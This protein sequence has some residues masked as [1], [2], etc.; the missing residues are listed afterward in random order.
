[1]NVQL[2]ETLIMQ[3]VLGHNLT[4][5]DVAE[6]QDLAASNVSDSVRKVLL[7]LVSSV[8]NGEE[9][10]ARGEEQELSPAEAA[11]EL[12]M[13]RTHLYK[14]LDRGEIDSHR[15]GSHRRI[16]ARDLRAFEEHRHAHRVEL[17]GKFAKQDAI[18]ADADKEIAD[19]L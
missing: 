1:M 3:N 15:V 4:P 11:R 10:V 14:L 17:A 5:N 19:L 9:I 7:E 12:G 13:S 18:A 2:E 8:H 16:R 6:I